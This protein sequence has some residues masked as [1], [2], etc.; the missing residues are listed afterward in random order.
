MTPSPHRQAPLAAVGGPF[1]TTRGAPG[2]ARGVLLSL[3]S[4]HGHSFSSHR[5]HAF[6]KTDEMF[7]KQANIKNLDDG[8]TA[9]AV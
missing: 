8:T 7:L 1:L 3:K 5:R 4:A 9:I 6:K 2:A